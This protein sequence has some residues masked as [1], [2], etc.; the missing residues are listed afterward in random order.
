MA[1]TP[2]LEHIKGHQDEETPYD[3][4]TLEAQMNVDPDTEAR[5]YQTMFPLLCPAITP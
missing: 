2:Q 3:D 4:L 5:S 1:A